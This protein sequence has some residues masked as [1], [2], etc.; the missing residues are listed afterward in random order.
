MVEEMDVLY[1]MAIVDAND[2]LCRYETL[3]RMMRVALCFDAVCL[4]VV[5]FLLVLRRSARRHVQET[6]GRMVNTGRSELG[7]IMPSLER[8]SSQI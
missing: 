1:D 2:R 7:S 8:H 4:M 6:T 5:G 3:C